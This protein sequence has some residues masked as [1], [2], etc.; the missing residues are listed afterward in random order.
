M[1]I[2]VY[3]WSYA[4]LLFYFEEFDMFWA[5]S[6]HLWYCAAK[7]ASHVSV[8][9]MF[10]SGIANVSLKIGVFILVPLG[11]IAQHTF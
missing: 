6:L 3:N 4:L 9:S 10:E 2:N 5:K 7:L 11:Y 8:L 1:F